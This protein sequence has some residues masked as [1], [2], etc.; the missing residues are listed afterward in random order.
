M[1]PGS[2]GV[3]DRLPGIES[4]Q[5]R[6][7]TLTDEDLARISGHDSLLDLTIVIANL[8]AI[9]DSGPHAFGTSFLA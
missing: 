4:L 5:I 7:T 1:R 6:K 3:L 9:T 2:S 8:G